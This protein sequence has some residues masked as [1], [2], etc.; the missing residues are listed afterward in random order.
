MLAWPWTKSKEERAVA[1][2]GYAD[3]HLLEEPI[4]E[5]AESWLCRVHSWLRSMFGTHK[6]PLTP[7]EEELR[8]E[9]RRILAAIMARDKE[10]LLLKNEIEGLHGKQEIDKLFTDSLNEVIQ[11]LRSHREADLIA[12]GKFIAIADGY[13]KNMLGGGLGNNQY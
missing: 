8:S 3:S 11:S 6:R 12:H 7:M 10:I 1:Y 9:N 13:L 4:T 5:V 2:T